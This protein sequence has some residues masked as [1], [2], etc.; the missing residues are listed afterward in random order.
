MLEMSSNRHELRSSHPPLTEFLWYVAF[1]T[2]NTGWRTVL[3]W[4]CRAAYTILLKYAS[5][6]AI[7]VLFMIANISASRVMQ[8]AVT[9]RVWVDNAKLQTCFLARICF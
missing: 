2:I 6:A 4:V 9:D 5:I 3:I 8:L 7:H 1:A